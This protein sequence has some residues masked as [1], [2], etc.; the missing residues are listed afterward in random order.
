MQWRPLVWCQ[1]F[2]RGEQADNLTFRKDI[3]QGSRVPG[4]KLCRV[5][6]KTVGMFTLAKQA[7]VIHG[8]ESRQ[9][10]VR[11][12]RSHRLVPSSESLAREVCCAARRQ[13]A[14]NIA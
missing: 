8:V 5:R 2:R 6:H 4:W 12:Q 7:Q 13:E 10:R 14:I 1:G 9:A 3:R 11:L